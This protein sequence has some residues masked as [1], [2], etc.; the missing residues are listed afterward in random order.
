M[1]SII[2]LHVQPQWSLPCVFFYIQQSAPTIHLFVVN[3]GGEEVARVEVLPLDKV[4]V[5][6]I[7]IEEQIGVPPHQQRLVHGEQQLEEAEPW[8]TYG[9]R[10]WSTV[11]LTVINDV[12]VYFSAFAP[13]SPSRA[14][15][16]SH[17]L[18]THCRFIFPR[19]YSSLP[20]HRRVCPICSLPWSW[21]PFTREKGS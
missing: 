9:V 5:G 7:Q 13:P 19:F 11:Q 16:H 15:S 3:W 10:N 2:S 17:P 8:S 21:I 18:C 12:C 14:Q 6:Q 20:P 4:L 1:T